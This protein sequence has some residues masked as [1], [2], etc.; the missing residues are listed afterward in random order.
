[1]LGKRATRAIIKDRTDYT[2]LLTELND[3]TV[4]KPVDITTPPREEPQISLFRQRLLSDERIKYFYSDGAKLHDKTCPLAR[5]IADAELRWAE[6]YPIHL[7][8]CPICEIQAYLRLG[9]RD[10]S[11]SAD[12]ERIFKEMQLTPKTLRRV[13]VHEKMNTEIITRNCLKIWCKEDVWLLNTEPKTHLLRLRHNNY[14]SKPD[15]SREFYP[16][17]HEQMLC[18]SATY[19]FKVIAGYT[20]DKHKAAVA[21]RQNHATSAEPVQQQTDSNPPMSIWQRL[22]RFLKLR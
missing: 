14:H 19:A 6:D 8:P 1:M 5:K 3:N 21:N 15:G 10:F 20:Y 13:Y 9:A 11:Q 22:K 17:F 12:Y 4:T 7:T 18:K 2:T 16:G